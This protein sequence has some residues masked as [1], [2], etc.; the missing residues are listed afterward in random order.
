MTLI[1][2][3]GAWGPQLQDVLEQV[4]SE[5]TLAAD[6]VP[7]APTMTSDVLRADMPGGVRNGAKNA[8]GMLFLPGHLGDASKKSPPLTKMVEL[9]HLASTDIAGVGLS[10]VSGSGKTKA[11]FD[12][13]SVRVM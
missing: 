11:A 3:L 13:L 5:L 8:V 4:S 9:L 1:A 7:E 10:N 6:F 12:L 2:S